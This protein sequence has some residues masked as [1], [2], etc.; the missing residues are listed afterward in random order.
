MGLLSGKTALIFG[1]ANKRSI[2]WGIAQAF[3]QQGATL[4]FYSRNFRN[5]RSNLCCGGGLQNISNNS[6]VCP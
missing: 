1:I 5:Q 6:M 4:G 3:H 2:A